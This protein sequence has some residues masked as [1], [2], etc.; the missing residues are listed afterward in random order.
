MGQALI[1]YRQ[2]EA[3]KA[4]METGT[5]VKA[6]EVMYLS[7]PAVSRLL[8]DLEA[9]IGYRLFERRKGRLTPRHEARELYAEVDKAFISL[10]MLQHAADR[11]GRI[12][13]DRL[14]VV[15]LPGLS[16][17]P[18]SRMTAKFLTENQTARL[19]IQVSSR[20]EAVEAVA[21]GRFDLGLTTLP[22]DH[23]GIEARVIKQVSFDCV[24]S[25]DHPLADQETITAAD[26]AGYS[27][28]SIFGEVPLRLC[29][30]IHRTLRH[31][32]VGPGIRFDCSATMLACATAAEGYGVVFSP[33]CCVNDQMR[34]HLSVVPFTPGI[35][36]D[37]GMIH[38][39][40][41]PPDDTAQG[42]IDAFRQAL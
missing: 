22:V 17:G 20:Q 28:I 1:S 39:K 29:G 13:A 24:M 9:G 41:R 23:P 27:Y 11:I 38:P 18:L 35:A 31:N 10:R 36:I 26:M 42:F 16:F 12:H 34:D 5:V 25:R 2:I 21:Q 6:A 15:A 30:Q 7:Q 37:I 8:S 19:S 32:D 40:D 4:V 14:R 3:F 33:S